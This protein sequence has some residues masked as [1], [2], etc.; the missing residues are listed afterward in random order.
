MESKCYSVAVIITVAGMKGG[1]GK[2]TTAIQIAGNLA[3]RGRTVLIDGDPNQS[4][5][6]WSRRGNCLPFDVIS[7]N[8]AVGQ[9]R[10]YQNIVMDTKARPDLDELRD[11]A[12]GCDLL[13]IPSTPDSLALEGLS[14][15]IDALH[16]LGARNFRV[17]LT[18]IPPHPSK[19][20]EDARAALRTADVPLF[21]RGIR[22]TAAFQAAADG[23]LLVGQV[24]S[25]DRAIS[26]ARDYQAISEE[27]YSVI[28]PRSQSVRA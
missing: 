18:I 25:N 21:A 24:K 4:A 12:E 9:A 1:V 14:L 2:T 19:A 26:G 13:V 3:E 28:E 16:K 17:L 11:L 8:K 27:L 6:G 20:G 15:T 5:L 22:R 7:L 23:G 10:N